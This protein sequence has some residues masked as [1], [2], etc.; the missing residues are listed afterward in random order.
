MQ[1]IGR[2][3]GVFYA[4]STV[5]S[6]LGT[7]LTGFVLIA[8][9]GVNR[10]FEVAGFLLIMLS[11]LFF[12][13]FK[14]NHRLLALL[15]LPL[16]ML[17]NPDTP[18][19]KVMPNGTTVTEVFSKDS[20]YGNL[21]VVDYS[22]KAVHTRELMIDGLVQ[23][24]IDMNNGLSIY[25]YAYF[26]EFLPY[27]LN[28]GGKNCL[29]IG[30]GA[31]LVP[32]WYDRNGIRTD[33]VDIDPAVVDIARQFFGF[34]ISG[35]IIL[36]DA[37]HFLTTSEKKYD[38]VVLDVFNGDTT[39]GHLLSL[40]A[41]LLIKERMTPRG[42]LAINLIGSLEEKN[43]MT[44]SAV[45]TLQSVF[46]NVDL[47]PAFGGKEKAG[48]GNLAIVSYSFPRPPIASA[49]VYSFPVHPWAREVV[50]GLARERIQFPASV[51]AIILTD[52]YNP[53]DFYDSR[54]KENVRKNILENTDRDILI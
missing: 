20:F 1:H 12:S 44:A 37:R 14:R 39:P 18:F 7:V 43:F 25:E 41:L 6:F 42:V 48:W 47:Y 40:Q 51:T 32:M 33:V 23:G 21:K 54:L 27:S 15:V 19:S 52:D 46:N 31:G 26:M 4:I 17:I 5:G 22:Y 29:V 11:V 36:S 3:V 38:Y 53:I 24:G 8:H 13:I 50:L 30:L 10:I 16:I 35:D 2:T 9:L 34:S 45:R 28:P 49:A